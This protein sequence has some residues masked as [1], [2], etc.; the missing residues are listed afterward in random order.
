MQRYNKPMLCTEYMA[1]PNGSTFQGFLPIA[2]KYKVAMFNWGLVDG[3]TQTKY[4]WDSWTKTYTS[5]PKV[6]FHEVFENNGEPYKIEEVNF[7]KE[8]TQSEN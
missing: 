4:P 6:W 8:I 7:I 2:K 3:K 5:E 1:R